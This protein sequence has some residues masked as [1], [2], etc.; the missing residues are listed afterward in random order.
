MQLEA[1]CDSNVEQRVPKHNGRVR[2]ELR[3]R[4]LKEEKE[5]EETGSETEDE[6]EVHE[7]ARSAN[8]AW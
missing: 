8:V 1:F 6:E 2:H 4:R 3:W 5:E 7:T